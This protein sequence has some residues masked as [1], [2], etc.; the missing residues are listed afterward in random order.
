MFLSTFL[1]FHIYLSIFF[2]KMNT[3]NEFADLP[4]FIKNEILNCSIIHMYTK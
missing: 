2:V 3:T 1:K 4:K